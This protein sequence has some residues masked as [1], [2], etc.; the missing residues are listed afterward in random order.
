MPLAS[1]QEREK[2]GGV[3]AHFKPVTEETVDVFHPATG[4]ELA[5]I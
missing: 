1:Y 2:S 5:D 3:V 4:E